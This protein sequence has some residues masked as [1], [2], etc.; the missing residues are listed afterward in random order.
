[1]FGFIIQS[2]VSHKL[3]APDVC[4]INLLIDPEDPYYH[5]LSHFT[6]TNPVYFLTNKEAL[7]IASYFMKSVTISQPFELYHVYKLLYESKILIVHVIMI[8]ALIKQ[9]LLFHHYP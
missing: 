8:T 4:C 2:N 1:M 6:E 9:S 7:K 3:S 5:L